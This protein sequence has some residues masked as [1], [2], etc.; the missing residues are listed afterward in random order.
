MTLYLL[1]YNNYYNRIVKYEND[2]NGYLAVNENSEYLYQIGRPLTKI[3]FN[4][5]DGVLTNQVINWNDEIP[6]YILVTSDDSLDTNIY[7]RWFVIEAV[8]ER[9]N[10]YTLS[11]KRDLVVDFLNPILNSPAFIEKATLNIGNK[12]IFN[13]ENG[14][15]YNQIKKKEKLLEENAWIVGYVAANVDDITLNITTPSTNYTESPISLSDIRKYVNGYNITGLKYNWYGDYGSSLIS[16]VYDENGSLIQEFNVSGAHPQ[17]RLKFTTSPS[18][19]KYDLERALKE[20]IV[21]TNGIAETYAKTKLS[22]TFVN[23]N[24]MSTLISMQGGIY[25]SGNDIFKI[26]INNISSND[27]QFALNTSDGSIYQQMFYLFKDKAQVGDIKYESA[28]ASGINLNVISQSFKINIE[29]TSGLEIPPIT[30]PKTAR[31]LTDAPYKMFAIPYNSI[32]VQY[33]GTDTAFTFRSSKY[34]ALEL[35]NAITKSF[36]SN[37]YDIQ[38]LPY[39]PVN[40]YEVG[41]L[42]LHYLSSATDYTLFKN[43]DNEYCGVILWASTSN[44]SKFIEYKINVPND[45]IEF[46]IANETQ[47]CRLCSPNYNGTF[48][49]KPTMNYGIRGFEINCTYKPFQPYIHV[50]PVFNSEGLYG[51]DFND[52]RGLLCTGDFSL[53]VVNDEWKQYQINNKSY[54]DAFKRQIENMDT[55]YNIDRKVQ[56]ASAILGGIS[57]AI[58]SATSG[59]MVGSVGGPAGAAAGAAVGSIIGAGANIG[60]AIADLKFMESRHNEAKSYAEDMYGYKLDN[61]KALPYSLGKA[62]AF[63]I[64]NKIFPFLEFYDCTDEEKEALRMKLLYNGMTTMT[65]GKISDYITGKSSFIQAQMV[66]INDIY[67]DYHIAVEIANEIHKGIYI[68]TDGTYNLIEEGVI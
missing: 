20:E 19:A 49:F 39:C 18:Y 36:G 51:G 37:L 30:I 46:K 15:S 29:Y 66:Q 24:I 28:D 52:Q 63:T 33:E 42:N 13:K 26:T 5:N 4:P 47:F 40:A 32:Y 17:Q 27:Q 64:N 7:S 23:D 58:S 61:I 3:N 14:I 56:T 12:L 68:N 62:T 6:D 8:R 38:L 67:D 11:L 31:T 57:G 1:K 48:E 45:P 54:E 44:F 2:L 59:A 16:F 9:K 60:G 21:N 53:P 34:I 55:M 10:Q 25:K 50:N 41:V 65:I 35:T 22:G 43:N